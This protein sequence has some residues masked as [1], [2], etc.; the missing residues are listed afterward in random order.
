V[1]YMKM[2]NTMIM[3]GARPPARW[4]RIVG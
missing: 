2:I 3:G 1:I 4:L